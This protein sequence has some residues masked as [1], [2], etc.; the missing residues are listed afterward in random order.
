MQP[1]SVI[2]GNTVTD[3]QRF[4]K[5]LQKAAWKHI[6]N[7]MNI[8]KFVTSGVMRKVNDFVESQTKYPFTMKNIYKMMDIILQT[9][10]QTFNQSIIEVFDKITKHHHGNRYEVEGWKTNKSYLVGQK[11]IIEW[12]TEVGFSGEMRI[13]Y[14]GN[15]TKLNDFHKALCFLTGT[16]PKDTMRVDEDG[17]HP[18]VKDLS[19]W[20]HRLNL[21]FG[22]WYDWGFFEI[23]G[24]KKGTLHCKFKDKNVWELFNRKV[25]EIKGFELPERF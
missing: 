20:P 4:A 10:E 5:D 25:A 24:F 2:Y 17:N 23:K 16:E 3:K 7:K 14:N 15:Q 11:F 6:F 19:I 9:R 21:E 22:T 12:V 1:Y 18:K 8:Q 13:K